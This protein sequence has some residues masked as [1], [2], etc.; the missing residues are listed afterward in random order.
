MVNN[1]EK[2]FITGLI[3]SVAVNLI[4]VIALVTFL[5]NTSNPHKPLPP[6]SLDREQALAQLKDRFQLTDAQMDTMRAIHKYRHDQ[7]KPIRDDLDQ[8]QQEMYI[9]LKSSE[10]NRARIDTLLQRITATQDSL[11]TASLNVLLRM[12]NVLTPEQLQKLPELFNDLQ[13]AGRQEKNN[14]PQKPKRL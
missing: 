1:R 5:C 11:E 8:L 4:A 10:F 13:K 14:K 2:W 3:I 9:Q 6:K 12:R 7:I